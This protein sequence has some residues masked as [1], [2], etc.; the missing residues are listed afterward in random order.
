MHCAQCGK[1]VA[2][3]M[4]LCNDCY[5]DSHRRYGNSKHNI[6]SN[7]DDIKIKSFGFGSR[8]PSEPT[9]FGSRP[10]GFR[11]G[12]PSDEPN[13]NSPNPN[14]NPNSNGFIITGIY[15]SNQHNHMNSNS[16]PATI[17]T[18]NP[19]IFRD[20]YSQRPSDQYY[21]GIQRPW[22]DTFNTSSTPTSNTVGNTS[23]TPTSNTVGNTSSTP[24]ITSGGKTIPLITFG[25]F[26][27]GKQNAAQSS[28]TSSNSNTKSR[29]YETPKRTLDESF[30]D[31]IVKNILQT[32]NIAMEDIPKP[33]LPKLADEDYVTTESESEDD[34]STWPFEWIGEQVKTIKDLIRI[35]KAYNPETKIASNLDMK[36]LSKIV[37]PLETLD[38]MIGLTDVKDSIFRKVVFHL[39]GLDKGNDDSE[40]TVIKGPPGVGKTELTH[41]IAK[42]YKGLGFLKKD[43][44]VSVKRDD[45]IAG[46]VGQTA[47]KTKKKLE[48][49]LGGVLL[50]DEAY[51]LGDGS[52]KDSFSKEAVDLLTSYLSEHKKDFICIIAGYKDAL[53]KRFFTINQG[54]ASRFTNHIEI[55]PYDA[56]ELRQIFIKTVT[57]GKWTLDSDNLKSAFF[58]TNLDKFP[59][60]GRDMSTLFG[61]CKKSHSTRLLLIRTRD[62]LEKTKKYLTVDDIE[63][64]YTH[65]IDGNGYDNSTALD[66]HVKFMYS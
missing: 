38:S 20:D 43:T 8:S 64:G 29:V 55:K 14:P 2:A 39:Q 51:S 35:G 46:Y 30:I 27:D 4:W 22:S 16:A 26:A 32:D 6:H 18:R 54:L 17:L 23:S 49:A 66:K 15:D 65:Y 60:S 57:E 9:Q 5:A 56:D 12:F 59:F 21:N 36:R 33:K 41:I 11:F 47:L 48:E 53:E 13:M 34:K 37:T 24:T 10:S 19:P 44:V 7:S 52:D 50:I 58:K 40:H 42:I 45:L 63:D 3:F 28:T 62:E 61:Y 25:M 31:A 1:S